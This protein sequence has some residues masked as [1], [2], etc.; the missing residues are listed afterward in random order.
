MQQL[1]LPPYAEAYGYADSQALSERD[2]TG[3]DDEFGSEVAGVDG[4]GVPESQGWEVWD[5]E[6]QEV[7]QD[8]E[9]GWL[10]EDDIEEWSD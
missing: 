5:D 6:S 10:K 7:N 4:M 8:E 9:L 1:T 2:V 3:A